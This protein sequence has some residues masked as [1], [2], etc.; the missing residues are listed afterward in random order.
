MAAVTPVDNSG[1][2]LAIVQ[3]AKE[4]VRGKASR[5]SASS[6]RALARKVEAK[7]SPTTASRAAAK[8]AKEKDQ[9]LQAGATAVEDL[10]CKGTA[11]GRV[12]EG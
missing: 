7:V 3:G 9:D 4:K 8:A 12:P 2:T 6:R 10:T 11:R 5:T 1:T